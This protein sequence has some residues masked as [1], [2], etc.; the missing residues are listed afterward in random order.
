MLNTPSDRELTPP[1]FRLII[2]LIRPFPNFDLWFVKKLR[3]RAVELLKLKPGDRALDGGCGPGGSFP[4]LVDAVG[5]SGEVIGVEIS[6]EVA[7]N[8][9][10]R[11]AARAWTNVRVIVGNAQTVEL[12]GTFQGMLFFG[13]PDCYASPRALDNMIPHLARGGRVA[14]FG[15]KLSQ[16]PTM[17]ILNPLFQKAFS[18]ATFASTPRLEV[19]PWSMLEQRLGKFDVQEYFFGIF[20]L[21]WGPVQPAAMNSGLS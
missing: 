4:V 19:E 18:R 13:A 7:I 2:G 20:F 15:A 3:R 1:Y 10:K 6:P 5:T 11:V 16:R 12:E 8:A 9:D 14:I 17:R 21:A